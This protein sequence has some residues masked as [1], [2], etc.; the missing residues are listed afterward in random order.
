MMERIQK[1]LFGLKNPCTGLGQQGLRFP[2]DA[3]Y[4]E[5]R[6]RFFVGRYSFIS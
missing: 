3:L 1:G 2:E 5:H 6:Q 4:A